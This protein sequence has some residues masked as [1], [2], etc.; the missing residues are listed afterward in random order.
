MRRPL[1]PFRPR[2]RV[3]CA[4]LLSIAFAGALVPA[5]QAQ[6][7]PGDDFFAYANHDWLQ[8]TQIP[9]GKQRWG[10]RDEIAGR[11]RQQVVKLLDDAASAPAGSMARKVADFRA[12]YMDEAAI[13]AHGLAPLKPLLE[14]IDG[15]NDKAA[16]ARFLGSELPADVDPMNLG[17]YDSSHILGLAVQAG[18]HGEKLHVAYLLQGGL[19]LADRESYLGT[20][21]RMQAQRERYRESIEPILAWVAGDGTGAALLAARA[22]AVV[23]LETAIAQSHLTA[24][25][26][27]EDHNADTLWTRA[28]FAREAPGMDW[29][30][31]FAAAGLASQPSF[32]LRLQS[33]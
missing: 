3:A 15:L 14:R 21:P 28:D 20:D 32:A 9:A 7:Q 27:S 5:A 16:L 26:S 1:S 8:A 29:D 33:E 23:A 31:F 12:A 13:E 4:A 25:A 22:Q 6:V 18:N 19:G 11:T 17:V 10:A 24:E 30:A 2:L